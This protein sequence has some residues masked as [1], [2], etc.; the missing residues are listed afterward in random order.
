MRSNAIWSCF[1]LAHDEMALVTER[2]DHLI[3]KNRSKLRLMYSHKDRWTP[4]SYYEGMK[5]DFPGVAILIDDPEIEHGFVE[6]EDHSKYLAS[7]CAEMIMNIPE[8]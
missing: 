4:L 5:E 8:Q 7:K 3:H 6:N 1:T 2:P